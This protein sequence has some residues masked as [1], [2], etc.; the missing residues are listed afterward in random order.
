MAA[1]LKLRRRVIG[2]E[3]AWAKDILRDITVTRELTGIER[4]APATVDIHFDFIGNGGWEDKTGR[5][6]QHANYVGYRVTGIR[7]GDLDA[8]LT[9]C[10]RPAGDPVG[11]FGIEI[12]G[13]GGLHVFYR[14]EEIAEESG[15]VFRR[16]F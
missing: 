12:N 13:Y 2:I 11:A 15:Q 4:E 1:V 3:P 8:M 10:K 5:T 7:K 9:I 6:F 16:F 14:G